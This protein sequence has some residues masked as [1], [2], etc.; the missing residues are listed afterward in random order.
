MKKITSYKVA[1][2]L[3]NKMVKTGKEIILWDDT[4]FNRIIKVGAVNGTLLE[5]IVTDTVN[6]DMF[7]GDMYIGELIT[8]LFKNR[9]AVNRLNDLA[10]L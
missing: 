1:E 8:E 7:R 6:G 9:K 2:E 5:V 10:S 3:A 4:D